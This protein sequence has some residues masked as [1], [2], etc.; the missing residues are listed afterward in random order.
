MAIENIWLIDSHSGICIYDWCTETKEKTIDE[1]LVSGLLLAFR[2]FSSEAGLVD[3]SAIEGID[4]KLAYKAD[5]RYIIAA[6]C[7]SNDYE[8]LV[9]ETLL[10]LLTDFRNKYKHLLDE[11][12]TTDV[13]PFR[14]F[15]ENITKKLEGTTASRNI[16]SLSVGAIITAA[17]IGALFVVYA[18]T[19]EL[20]E[21][22]LPESGGLL[23]LI[24]LLVG[25][26]I[27]GFFGGMVAGERRSGMIA[28]FISV[29]PITAL[30]IAFFSADWNTI[31]KMIINSALFLLLF[32]VMA[33][34]GGLI[35]GYLKE[36]RFLYPEII[37]EEITE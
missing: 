18:F 10:G 34:S 32:S 6:I 22:A 3:I 23:G 28:S 30:F 20:I 31:S 1:Q 36:R 9:N 26:I 13:S 7:H 12:A 25:F 27:S 14:T 15:E 29:L 5:D 16:V 8:P 11:G 35:G 37:D 33:I 2:N 24:I 4:R 17:V 21:A 19:I